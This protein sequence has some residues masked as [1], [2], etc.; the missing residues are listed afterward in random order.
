MESPRANA[1]AGAR[2]QVYR[3]SLT[4]PHRPS[5]INVNNPDLVREFPIIAAH[6]FGMSME[7][8]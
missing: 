1:G 8:A 2:N 5:E 7:A 4:V 3:G 6:W